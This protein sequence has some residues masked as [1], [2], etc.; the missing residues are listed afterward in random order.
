[1]H[2][3]SVKFANLQEPLLR[4][5]LHSG[6]SSDKTNLRRN[7][8]IVCSIYIREFIVTWNFLFLVS[9]LRRTLWTMKQRLGV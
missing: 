7:L 8:A 5:R 3:S 2:D 9:M 4:Y 1:M 6:Q